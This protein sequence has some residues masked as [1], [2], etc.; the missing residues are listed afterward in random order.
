MIL[1]RDECASEEVMYKVCALG[2]SKVYGEKDE[3]ELSKKKW[4]GAIG[5]AEKEPGK[6]DV[7]EAK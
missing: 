2:Y 1:P 4:E 6:W 5:E 7:M 3:E